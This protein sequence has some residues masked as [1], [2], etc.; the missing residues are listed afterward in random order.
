MVSVSG[1]GSGFAVSGL[2]IDG[3]AGAGAVSIASQATLTSAQGLSLGGAAGGSGTVSVSGAQSLLSNTG[4]FLAGDAGVGGLAIQAGGTVLTSAGATIANTAGANGS[5]VSVL[6]AGSNWHVAGTLTAGN[7][8][9]ASLSIGAGGAVFAGALDAA[10]AALAVGAIT[11]TDPGSHLT[12]AGNAT[13]GDDGNGVLAIYGGAT[14]T[15]GGDLTLGSLGDANGALIVSGTGSFL[16][17]AGSLNIGTAQGFGDVTVG[18]GGFIHAGVIN[19]QGQVVL[20]GGTL[21]P[22]VDILNPGAPQGGAGGVGGVNGSGQGFIINESTIFS[23]T[24]GTVTVTGTIVGGGTFLKNGTAQPD[25]G[26]PGILQIGTNTTMVLVSPVL[27]A[28]STTFQD[29]LSSPNTY[30]VNNS[31]VDVVFDGATGVLQ[32]NA[33]AGFAGTVTAFQAGDKFVISGGTLSGL[34]VVNGTTLTVAD[35]GAG[36]GAGGIDSIIFGAGISAGQFALVNGNTIVAQALCVAA[37]T[38][39]ATGD[40]EAAVET[41]RPGDLVR[42]PAGALR[43]VRWIG[44]RAID[45]AR[46]PTPREVQPVRIRAGALAD[47]VPKRDL[48]VSPEH[49][50]LLEGGLVPARLLLNGTSIVQETACRF[51]TWYHLELES[52]D[53]LLAEGAAV[54]SYLDTGNRWNFANGGGAMSL[55]P[56]FADGQ[57][58]AE[59]GAYGQA[60]RLGRSCAPFWD[61][62]SVVEPIWRRLAARGAAAGFGDPWAMATTADPALTVVAGGRVFRPVRAEAG[63]YVFALPALAGPA[64]L[65]SRA[66]EACALRPWVADRRVLG[67]AVRGISVA[68]DGTTRAIPVDDPG[69]VEG[70]WAAERDA[71]CSWRWT[72]GDAVL[73]VTLTSPMVL[74]VE[75]GDGGGYAVA[76]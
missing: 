8:G 76:A 30:T 21:D 11:V 47:R 37:G 36:A 29:D 4:A 52:H 74:A 19:G 54:E 70:W 20:E 44:Q 50:L 60:G 58:D 25:A 15:V 39:I 32:L 46:H 68:Q 48:R 57:G 17:V 72:S 67:V 38:R 7:A 9:S 69:L 43:P 13:I 42:T 5:A 12:I 26:G 45:A 51:V 59:G 56:S 66:G 75:I 40:G 18:T 28:A 3:L 10:V 53:V 27:N 55:H 1:L 73:P 23:R 61:A 62:A 31:V 49:A 24:K 63:R 16:G 64:R 34:S 35:S 6:G 22:A 71:S 33:I 14:V 65:V 41:L 2:L